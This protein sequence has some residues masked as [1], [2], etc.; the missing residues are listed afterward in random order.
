MS[1]ALLIAPA[2]AL[3]LLGAHF[4]RAGLWP[5]MLA[6]LVLIALLA[7]RRAWVARLVQ[8]CLVIG[9]IVWVWTAY[10][11]V[12]Q[13]IAFG[14]PWTRLALILGTV[15]VLTAAAALVFRHKRLRARFALE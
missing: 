9:A 8:G 10:T 6:C 7:W 14:Q 12:Q 2:S 4:Y 5:L 13:R 11:F 1:I 3:V 15:A